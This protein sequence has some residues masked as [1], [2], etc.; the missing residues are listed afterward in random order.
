MAISL[1][2]QLLKAGLADNKR[3]RQAD[4]ARRQAAKG[5]VDGESAADAVQK[6]RAEQAERDRLANL[7]RQAEQAVRALG[8]QVRQLIE[9]H[10]IPRAG[11]DVAWQ[12]ADGRKVRKMLVTA[13]Q[14]YQLTQGQVA[15]VRLESP[16]EEPRHELVPAVVAERIRQRLPDAVVLL[17]S[18]PVAQVVDEDDP[19][20]DYPIPDDLMW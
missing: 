13:A 5:H 20:K 17:N 16:G 11:G 12:Y 8:P 10:R 4:H 2:D 19:Y 1:K 15:I 9:A 18:R 14:Q 3:A 6:A 7:A